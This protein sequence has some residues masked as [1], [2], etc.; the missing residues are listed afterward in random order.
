MSGSG[1]SFFFCDM[2]CNT[3]ECVNAKNRFLFVEWQ[4]SNILHVVCLFRFRFRGTDWAG[5][6]RAF[7]TKRVC[8]FR[9]RCREQIGPVFNNEK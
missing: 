6:S 8:Q 5:Q 4:N 7:K 1:A 2:I 3:G 9:F